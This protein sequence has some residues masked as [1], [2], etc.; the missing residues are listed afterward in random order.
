MRV[1]VVNLDQRYSAWA[2]VDATVVLNDS[3]A[4]GVPTALSVTGGTLV[5]LV[6]AWASGQSLAILRRV[7]LRAFA[8]GIYG[9]FGYHVC[10]F[11]ALRMAPPLEESLINYLWPLLIV[12]LAGALPA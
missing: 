12:V 4:P 11:L 6:Y 7:P 8:L 5:G 10:Y 3:V 2:E 9:L 1:R